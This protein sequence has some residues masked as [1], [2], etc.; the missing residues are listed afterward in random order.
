MK[1]WLLVALIVSATT[2]GQVLQSAGMR[3]HGEVRAFHPSALGRLIGRLASSWHIGASV[4]CM[5]FSFFA[6]M[7]LVSVADLSF[8]VPATALSYVLQ[9]VLAKYFL[10]ERIDWRR[11]VGALLVSCGVALLAL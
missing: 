4:V 8:A 11:W 7:S 5:A 3:R 1:A 10:K 9:T 6:F 2:A